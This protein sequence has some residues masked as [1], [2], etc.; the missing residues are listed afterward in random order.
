[1]KSSFAQEKERL[2]DFKSGII[3]MTSDLLGQTVITKKYYDDYLPLFMQVVE[4]VK[5]EESEEA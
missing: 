4:E 3:T 2:V 5:K 1:M